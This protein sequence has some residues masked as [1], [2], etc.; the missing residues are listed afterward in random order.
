MPSKIK[1]GQ[2]YGPHG[3]D[4]LL[5]GVGGGKRGDA[6]WYCQGRPYCH[7]QSSSILQYTV[8][9]TESRRLSD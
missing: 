1:M 9:V 2:A 6:I 8:K 4:G 7:G 5:H 3:G